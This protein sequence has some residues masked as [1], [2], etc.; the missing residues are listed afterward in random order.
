MACHGKLL[1]LHRPHPCMGGRRSAY[2]GLWVRNHLIA[3]QMAMAN[4]NIKESYVDTLN[5]SAHAFTTQV[6]EISNIIKI[7]NSSNIIVLTV[8]F[9]LGSSPSRDQI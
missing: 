8:S 2:V 1:G 7:S 6:T 4:A 5:M 3:S 9:R